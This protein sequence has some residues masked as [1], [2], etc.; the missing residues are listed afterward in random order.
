MKFRFKLIGIVFI[1]IT[2]FHLVAVFLFKQPYFAKDGATT[3]VPA[4]YLSG[5]CTVLLLAP[6]RRRLGNIFFPLLV[7]ILSVYLGLNIVFWIS[8]GVNSI[9]DVF[10][11]IGKNFFFLWIV[12]ILYWF[13]LLVS[14]G[15]F[16]L[17]LRLIRE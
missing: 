4:T 11:L 16:Y 13:P 10:E 12:L 6:L 14:Y 2:L 15:I 3:I 17:L 1:A 5:L 8:G 7:I 9:E